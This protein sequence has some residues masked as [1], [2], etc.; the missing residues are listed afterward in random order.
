M[1]HCVLIRD[2][3][4]EA[5]M[6]ARYYSYVDVKTWK[7]FT[8]VRIRAFVNTVM[9]FRVPTNVKKCLQHLSCSKLLKKVSAPCSQLN[10][11]FLEVLNLL[12]LE[13]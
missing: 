8:S 7:I 3:F 4:W 13:L 5:L 6:T 10:Y 2:L 1:N 11:K 12:L 9:S